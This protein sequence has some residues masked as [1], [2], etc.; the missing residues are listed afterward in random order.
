MCPEAD[1]PRMYDAETAKAFV[2]AWTGFAPELVERVLDAKFRYLEL[3]GIAL[4]EPN[5]TL[6]REREI[7]CDLLPETSEFIDERERE[8]LALVTGLDEAILLR[9]EQGDLAYQDTLGILEWDDREERDARLGAP[10]LPEP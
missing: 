6:Q 5:E 4:S 10:E 7:Y 3:A 2:S 8:Y 1:T 9:I